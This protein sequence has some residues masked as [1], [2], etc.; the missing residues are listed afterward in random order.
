MI[1]S[2]IT[3]KFNHVLQNDRD[4]IYAVYYGEHANT[5]QSQLITEGSTYLV[6]SVTF[7]VPNFPPGREILFKA[8]GLETACY[9]ES[10]RMI[11]PGEFKVL[12]SA[13][14]EFQY[15]V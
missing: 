8:L 11:P 1:Q 9:T 6:P 3:L 13:D 12:L 5:L 10:M 2:T 4:G 14:Q 15:S 7:K